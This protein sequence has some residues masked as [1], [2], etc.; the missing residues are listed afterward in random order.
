VDLTTGSACRTEKFS[1]HNMFQF[2]PKTRGYHTTGVPKPCHLA[3][4]LTRRA[5]VWYKRN[6]TPR[7]WHYSWLKMAAIRM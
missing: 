7:K 2:P 6:A 4:S 5:S 1:D 3:E